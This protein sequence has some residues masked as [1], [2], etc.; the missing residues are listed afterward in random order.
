MQIQVRERRAGELRELR[1]RS[2]ARV[3]PAV[4]TA[5]HGDWRAPEP[6]TRQRPVDVVL[7]PVP[8]P[9]VLDVLG[10]PADRLVLTQHRL[11][12]RGC[13]CEPGGLGPVD[14][15]RA[16]AP[17]VRVGVH[18]GLDGDEAAR[19]AQHLDELA[20]R[21]LHELACDCGDRVGE[22]RRAVDR[23]EHRQ[24]LGLCDLAV[25]LAERRREVHDA[26]AV[27]GGHEVG[28]DDPPAVAF[29]IEPVERSL[30]VKADQVLDRDGFEDLRAVAEHRVDPRPC[31]H[32]VALAGLR[33][34]HPHVFDVRADRRADVRDQGPR[35]RRPD[36]EVEA[37]VHDRKPDV[38]GIVGDVAVCPRLTELVARERGPA[39]AAVR[40]DLRAFVELFGI[41]HL[42]EEPPHAL[43]VGVVHRPVRIGHVEPHA[44]ASGQCGPV[45]DVALHGFAA[46][47]V[48]RLDAEFFDLG[49]AGEAQLLL[50]LDLD[51]E[52]MAVPARLAGHVLA[53]H[54]VE[55][56]VDVLEEPGPDVVDPGTPVGRRRALVEDPFLGTRPTA[57]ALGEDVVGLPGRQHTVFQLDEVE[58]SI[59]R[60]EGHGPYDKRRCPM[61]R[62]SLLST[63]VMWSSTCTFSPTRGAPQS[64]GGTAPR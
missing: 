37:P 27:L 40:D 45:L 60:S 46:P 28:R 3:A 4:A 54:G 10:V 57:H 38:H 24:A 53:P 51:R 48:E 29:G 63:M 61:S 33:R 20:V 11:L 62:I 12:R 23:V 5:P 22:A 17:A 13:A 21:V 19:L 55:P 47:L 64:W 14:Q 18:V 1:D 15:R 58:V 43:D 6:V 39:P 16:A 35:G 31:H 36:Q 9:P 42:A 41:P 30:V 56:R 32:E 44:D 52:A 26:A 8:E 7:E 59:D 2:D 49:L 25:D 50:D 34:A